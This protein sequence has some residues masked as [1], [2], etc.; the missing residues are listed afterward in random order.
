MFKR[1]IPYLL[2]FI[3]G[4]GVCAGAG[5]YFIYRPSLDRTEQFRAESDSLKELIG[6]ERDYNSREREIIGSNDT[7]ISKLRQLL[8]IIKEREQVR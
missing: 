1:F 3:L 7:S 4:F 8:L 6:R 5:Y 2:C